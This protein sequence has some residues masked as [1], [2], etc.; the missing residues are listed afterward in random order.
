MLAMCKIAQPH[1]HQIELQIVPLS[2]QINDAAL[3][4]G[5]VVL[6]NVNDMLHSFICTG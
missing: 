6:P 5:V 2:K 4:E 3:S 1:C